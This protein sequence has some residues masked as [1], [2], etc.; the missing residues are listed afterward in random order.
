MLDLTTERDAHMDQRLR[1]DPMIWLTTVRRDG[2]PHTMPVWSLWDGSTILILCQ[3]DAVKIRN[4]RTNTKVTLALDGTRAGGDVVVLEG[5]AEVL[6]AHASE[7]NMTDY[8]TKYSPFLQQMGYTPECVVQ[9]YSQPIRIT[10]TK[11]I[12]WKAW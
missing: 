2:R 10:P 6:T 7:L 8:F 11:C 12:G 4:L 5:R 3:P 9:S 1:S